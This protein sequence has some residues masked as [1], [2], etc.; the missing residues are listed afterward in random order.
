MKVYRDLQQGSPEWAALRA[1][2]P[3]AS[4]FDKIL[5]PTGKRSEQAQG[6]MRHLIAERLMGI[7]LDAPKTSWMER[8][9]EMEGEAICYYEFAR[10]VAIERV[11]FITNDRG[12]YGC[13]PDGLVGDDGLAE[14][15]CPS[16]A[17]HV[18]YMLDKGPDK[19]YR[20]QLQGQL[21]VAQRDWVE[22]C[23]YHPA[24]PSVIVR[25]DRDEKYITLLA[26]ALDEF[27]ETLA[28]ECVRLERDGYE[29]KGARAVAGEPLAIKGA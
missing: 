2:M 19:A 21:F 23:S 27:A 11:G 28:A 18:N 20:V 9:N 12:T 1:G 15:K 24:L 16:P 25:V 22:I 5:T 14:F 26:E 4:S 7:P 13:S 17:V 6:Y 3:T 29:F 8:G 10:D